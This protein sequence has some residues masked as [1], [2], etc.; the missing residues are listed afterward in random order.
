MNRKTK[1]VIGLVAF[2]AVVSL[3]LYL[4]GLNSVEYSVESVADYHLVGTPFK[5]EG[6]SPEIEAAFVEAR[7]YVESGS[8]SGI[9]TIVHYQD[10]TLA[11]DELKMFIGVKLNEGAS[12]IPEHYQRMTIPATNA[13]RASISAH[14]VVMPS[15]STIEGNIK[16]TAK[17]N[18][19]E[20]QNFT[21]E[22]YVSENLLLIDMP[23][24][25]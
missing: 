24:K 4:G 5:G 23:V 15:P 17:D 12:D 20:L 19:L 8:I 22:Q 1:I 18:G 11:E 13:V 2:V 10:T 16:A 3:Y 9:L 21:V 14:N 25:Q 7:G 6:D